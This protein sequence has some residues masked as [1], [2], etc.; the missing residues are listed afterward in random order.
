[1]DEEKLKQAIFLNQSIQDLRAV[2]KVFSSGVKKVTVLF[3]GEHE[4]V[5]AFIEAAP[6]SKVG[7]MITSSIDVLIE[8]YTNKFEAL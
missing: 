8:S 2:R 4:G 7:V 5:S 1:M 3:E 6:T